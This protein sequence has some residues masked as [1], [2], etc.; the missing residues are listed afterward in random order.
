[1]IPPAEVNP[2]GDK[3]WK[4]LKAMYGL[5][6][7]PKAWQDH[8]AK[9]MATLGFRRLKSEPNVYVNSDT[10]VMVLS[11]VDDLLYS[12][13]KDCLLYTSDAADD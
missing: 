8:F 2:N 4:L 11:Y 10:G 5:R 6:S 1:M 13:P 12:G 9:I 7:A 3:L